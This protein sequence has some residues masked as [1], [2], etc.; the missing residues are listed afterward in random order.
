MQVNAERTHL[1]SSYS[2]AVWCDPLFRCF[3]G[4][5]SNDVRQWAAN[6]LHVIRPFS[7]CC[8]SIAKRGA[9]NDVAQ[10]SGIIKLFWELSS[11]LYLQYHSSLWYG[12]ENEHP[13]S[14]IKRGAPQQ[15]QLFARCQIFTY[16]FYI[17]ELHPHDMVAR[18]APSSSR[19]YTYYT[20]WT[21]DDLRETSESSSSQQQIFLYVCFFLFLRA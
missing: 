10:F 9:S 1:Q 7:C 19:D 15:K 18:L 6:S 2:L 21:A 11:P 8:C 4:A 16:I 13:Y 17:N 12:Y 3:H 20:V 14:A 5:L